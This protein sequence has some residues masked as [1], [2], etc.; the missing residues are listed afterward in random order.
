MTNI[1]PQQE[2]QLL[3][4]EQERVRRDL[5]RNITNP[6]AKELAA[7]FKSIEPDVLIEANKVIQ[8]PNKMKDPA[9][10][11]WVKCLAKGRFPKKGKHALSF[12]RSLSGTPNEQKYARKLMGSLSDNTSGSL[13][14]KVEKDH[15]K[16]LHILR[17]KDVQEETRERTRS[18]TTAI[19]TSAETR[20]RIEKTIEVKND[21]WHFEQP[22]EKLKER[23]EKIDQ[24]RLALFHKSNTVTKELDNLQAEEKKDEAKI[25]KLKKELDL[26]DK[27][28]DALNQKVE[29]LRTKFNDDCERINTCR[30]IIQNFSSAIYVKDAR[31]LTEL[32]TWDNVSS[33]RKN[34]EGLV[35]NVPSTEGNK[36]FIKIRKIYFER[37]KGADRTDPGEL[38]ID[39]EDENGVPANPKDRNYRTFIALVRASKAYEPINSLEEF[40]ER[41]DQECGYK[42]PE[43]GQI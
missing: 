8:D 20:K 36:S 43:A 3:S 30:K 9:Y 2:G 6:H 23:M 33:E 37:K 42:L 4:L 13:S 1:K 32:I 14:E 12:L 16:T 41:A 10:Q 39:Y 18:T 7:K 29:P 28:I 19:V 22:N 5:E 11:Q 15:L 24:E 21:T 35:V 26:L 34:V 25:Q 27:K 31:K 17:E 38:K 40:Y